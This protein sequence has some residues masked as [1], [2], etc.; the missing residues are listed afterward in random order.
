MGL[1]WLSRCNTA[2]RTMSLSIIAWIAQSV[3]P[4]IPELTRLIEKNK[5][6]VILISETWLNDPSAHSM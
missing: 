3:K 1:D 5:Y 2:A 6:Q 4:K